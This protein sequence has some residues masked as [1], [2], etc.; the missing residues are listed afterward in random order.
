L[1]RLRRRALGAPLVVAAVVGCSPEFDLPSEIDSVWILAVHKDRPYARPE[2]TVT[3]TMLDHDGSRAA[4]RPLSRF[5]L[6]GCENPPGDLYA[7]CFQQFAESTD[8]GG[9]QIGA[10]PQ[11]QLRL[12]SDILSRRPPPANPSTPPYGL[13]YVFFAICAGEIR[14]LPPGRDPEFPLGCFAADGT[15]L[16]QDDFVVGYS[17]VY[18]YETLTN[19]NPRMLG[20]EVDGV[21]IEHDCIGLA[22]IPDLEPAVP[23]DGG[24]GDA[25]GEGGVDAGSVPE[26]PGGPPPLGARCR[27]SDPRC[28][29]VCTERDE[30][31]CPPIPIRAVA[32]PR[33]HDEDVALAAA[34]T[35]GVGEQMWLNYY[36]DRGSVTPPVK[37]LADANRGWNDDHGTELRAPSTP[38]PLHVW[39]VAHD[40]RG[41]VG[42]VR[43]SFYVRGP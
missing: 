35:E 19:R 13:A 17:A 24:T 14:P 5:W 31:R 16:G 37:L 43:A 4:P 33:S 6:G 26:E 12:S 28:I 29:P 27:L 30:H 25:G 34:G 1:S 11:F 38:G 2:D 18:V 20:F 8:L 39:G 22:C 9:L 7:G 23:A 21:R 41:G 10:G 3:F 32:D 42:W 36:V 15:R 40:N